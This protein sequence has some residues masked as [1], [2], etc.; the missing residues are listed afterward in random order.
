LWRGPSTNSGPDEEQAEDHARSIEGP[1]RQRVHEEKLAHRQVH[2]G[3]I[4]RSRSSQEQEGPKDGEPPQ[5]SLHWEGQNSVITDDG[6]EHLDKQGATEHNRAKQQGG[7]EQ[8]FDDAPTG[9]HSG[10]TGV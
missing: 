10:A 2:Q 4:Q 8:V 5:R 1:T 9:V 6:S 3:C 7:S